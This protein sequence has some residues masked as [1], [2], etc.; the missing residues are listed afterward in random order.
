MQK[1]WRRLG[2]ESNL[3]LDSKLLPNNYIL[4]SGINLGPIFAGQRGGETKLVQLLG[5]LPEGETRAYYSILFSVS[6]LPSQP[7][8]F[9][10]TLVQRSDLGWDQSKVR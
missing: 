9:S 1:R 10:S 5:E 2:E 3:K 8:P 6:S 4:V 7:L